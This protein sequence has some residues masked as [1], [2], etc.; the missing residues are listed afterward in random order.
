MHF[1]CRPSFKF[2]SWHTSLLGLIGCITMCFVINPIYA[3]VAISSCLVL[4]IVL[5]MRDL[6]PLW[7]SIS[8]ALIFHQVRKYLLRLDSR[9]AH[10]KFW[11]PQMLLMVANPRACCE[12]I[13]FVNDMKKG[14]LYVLGHVKVG[15]F[16][17][18]FLD[19]CMQEYPRWQNLVDQLKVKAFIELTLARSIREGLH[20]LVRISGLGGMKPNT[21]CFGFYDNA[22]P[23]DSFAKKEKQAPKR[24]LKFYGGLS[25][26][27]N[28]ARLSDAFSEL[29][30]A[31]LKKSLGV[32]EYVRM[33]GDSLKMNKNV[34]LFR[35]FSKLDKDMIMKNRGQMHVDIWPVN[36][37]EPETAKYVD[38]TCL[39]MLQLACILHRVPGWKSKTRLRVFLCVNGQQEDTVKERKLSQ[40]LKQ[41]R[42]PG[43]IQLVSWEHLTAM[44]PGSSTD[45]GSD[46]VGHPR[47]V[48]YDLPVDYLQGVNDL[49]LRE[50]RNTAVL[51][52]YLPITPVDTNC[53]ASYLTDLEILTRGLPPTVL[54]HG[55]HPVTSTI[56]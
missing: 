47:A 9:K 7:G 10:V 29:R 56:L 2:F 18:E 45:S 6:P 20:H 11:R 38:S 15:D 50:C 25:G 37:F 34:C 48:R 40:L 32:D 8:Q 4:V 30:T 21:I 55:I 19:P 27:D 31:G 46:F 41:L 13:D 3:S 36:F 24:K 35:Y 52:C 26:S 53:H 22:L 49:V 42:I 28:W 44:V 39:F 16:D 14:G 1:C 51:F 5:H 12:L 33:V 54:V 43:Q 17:Q 23:Q